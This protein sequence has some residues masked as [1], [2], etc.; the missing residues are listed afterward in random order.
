MIDIALIQDALEGVKILEKKYEWSSALKSIREQLEFL[1]KI[2]KISDENLSKIRK[3][4]IGV[5]AAREVQDMNINLAEKLYKIASQ[6][7]K[8]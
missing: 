4:N 5:L 7:K 2:E 1:E 8:L 6:I 3:L